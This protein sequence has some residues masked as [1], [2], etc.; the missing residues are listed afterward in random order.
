MLHLELFNPMPGNPNMI[1]AIFVEVEGLDRLDI[2]GVTP[3][4][5]G[6]LAGGRGNLLTARTPKFG[7][8]RG[9]NTWYGIGGGANLGIAPLLALAVA[10]A[11]GIL[12]PDGS[13]SIDPQ[14]PGNNTALNELMS[15]FFTLSSITNTTA[16]NISCPQDITIRLYYQD[17][18]GNKVGDPY[19]TFKVPLDK[20][21]KDVQ[22][23]AYLPRLADTGRGPVMNQMEFFW[24][25][26][27]DG[28]VAATNLG[29]TAPVATGVLPHGRLDHIVNR[30][31]PSAKDPR[32]ALIFNYCSDNN[33]NQST[34]AN[35]NRPIYDTV[36]SL[37]IAHGDYRVSALKPEVP[38]DDWRL[39]T[40]WTLPGNAAVNLMLKQIAH[41]LVMDTAID[42]LNNTTIPANDTHYNVVFS[43]MTNAG[44]LTS[45]SDFFV[46]GA[47]ASR[48]MGNL[49]NLM[50]AGVNAYNVC[51]MPNIPSWITDS[52]G[53]TVG[54]VWQGDWDNGIG[55]QSDGPYGNLPDSGNTFQTAATLKKN[56]PYYYSPNFE[57]GVNTLFFSPNRLVPSSGMLGSVSTGIPWRTLLFRPNGTTRNANHPGANG[58]PDH[59]FMDWFWMPVVDPY[60][61]SEPFSTAGKI[62]MN[63]QILP[64]KH[65]IRKT[66]LYSVLKAEKIMAIPTDDAKGNSNPSGN[67]FQ[68]EGYKIYGKTGATGAYRNS[69]DVEKTLEQ[70]DDRFNDGQIFKSATE[71]CDQYLVPKG[72]NL[73]AMASYWQRYL[74]TGDNT[75]ERPYTN[76]Y[77]RLTTK[78]NTYRV[79]YRVQVLKKVTGTPAN[80]FVDPNDPS[81]NGFKDQILSEQRGS[82]II[83]RYLEH[84]DPRFGVS[85][86][87]MNESLNKAYKFRVV[88]AKQFNP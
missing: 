78:S 23:G 6:T 72:Q 3:Y 16:I 59:L 57:H 39:S 64:F 32:P 63:Y 37:Q 75:K 66:G 36:L 53:G 47:F 29:H 9:A 54:G 87:P 10:P 7:T 68:T 65:I 20:L 14:K 49:I 38:A 88:G 13:Y 27:R 51:A 69:I 12:P 40:P 8:S 80:Q 31:D 74:P 44:G 86:D 30:G 33:P 11:R 56:P 73:S 41:N 83:E 82:Y 77:P 17:E 22:L 25:F 81:A 85:I 52:I 1:P 34:S 2:N 50:Q 70:F 18:N 19:Q 79:H 67:H 76:I 48:V 42:T 58:P 84:N 4:N 61:I 15:E 55:A 35:L 45:A 21:G 60:A 46:C 5:I 71:I 24:A 28:V 26:N 62:N 43:R